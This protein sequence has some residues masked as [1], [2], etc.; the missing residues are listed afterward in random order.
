MLGIERRVLTCDF[1]LVK[2]QLVFFL[3]HTCVYVPILNVLFSFW[4][5]YLSLE[6]CAQMVEA[7]A[8]KALLFPPFYPETQENPNC[9]EAVADCKRKSECSK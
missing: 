2:F 7:C 6:H 1:T 8:K 3:F 9:T 4:T 5:K